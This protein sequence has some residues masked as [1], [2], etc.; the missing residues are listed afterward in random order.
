LS[1]AI[2]I[3][4]GAAPPPLPYIYSLPFL[5]NQA[6]GYSSFIA[7]QNV[8]TTTAN[9]YVLSYDASGFTIGADTTCP[10]LAARAE[11]IPA[12]QFSPGTSGAGIIA[13][14]QPL[15]VVVAEATPFG[16]SAYAVSNG[17]SNSLVA[18]VAINNSL[19]F[20][21]GLTIF[22]ASA[23]PISGTV[24]FYDASGNHIGAADKAFSATSHASTLLYQGASDSSLPS[25]YY[26]WAQISSPLT[27]TIL[28]AQVVEQNPGTHFVAIANAQPNPTTT[29]Y[30]PAIFK[31]AF[32]N[33]ITGANIVNPNATP[34]TV[35]VTYRAADGTAT[36][37][38]PFVLPPYNLAAIYQG[39]SSGNGLPTGGLPDGFAGSATITATGGVVMVVNEAGGLT[40]G[41]T[42]QSGT[43]AAAASGSATVGL[44]VIAN[45]GFS[46]ITG[47]TILNTSNNVITGTIQYYNVD[48]SVQG[49]THPF[50]IQPYASQLVFQGDSAQ[51]L[52]AGFYGTAIVTETASSGGSNFK[53]LIITTNAQS[54][55]FFYT[56]TEPNQ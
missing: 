20:I 19:G 47:A 22:N 53:D 18:P 33:F 39:A 43:Y 23:S 48:G 32:G 46:Y 29:L 50:T 21:T 40:A 26:G 11:C 4:Q 56:Y 10:T 28:T 14:D 15:N 51:G 37:T 2:Q 52:G 31:K 44:P 35:T 49:T 54:N 1:A 38:A 36:N 16:G 17:G 6:A 27:T 45:G 34:V 5:A 55:Q 3:G 42:A 13:S 30:A 7:F 41:G 8:G 24:Q 25:G 12:N 9:V